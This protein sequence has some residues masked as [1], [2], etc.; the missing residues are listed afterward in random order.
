MA[1]AEWKKAPSSNAVVDITANLP[2]QQFE[3]AIS[4]EFEQ[5]M[6]LRKRSHAINCVICAQTVYFCTV[7]NQ[8][9]EKK[10]D[11]QHLNRN[12]ATRLLMEGIERDPLL[13]GIIGG[14]RLGCHIANALIKFGGVKPAELSISTRRPETLS[15]LQAK[16]V[17]CYYD[18][19]KLVQSVHLIF[20]C[21]LPAQLQLVIDDIKGKLTKKT[22]LYSLVPAAHITR[23][24]QLLNFQF[25]IKPDIVWNYDGEDNWDYSLGFDEVFEK[26]SLVKQTCPLGNAKKSS[27]VQCDSKLAE[28]FIYAVVN[29]CTQFKI[30]RRDTLRMVHDVIF[31]LTDDIPLKLKAEHF[32]RMKEDDTSMPFPMFDLSLIAE[33]DT[34]LTKK[35]SQVDIIHHYVKR[36]CALFEE[37]FYK[38]KWGQGTSQ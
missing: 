20:L 24:R 21:V 14:G 27:M 35:L 18:N 9:R 34:P 25:I 19:A 6:V 12:R 11:L 2:T 1:D 7:L 29:I 3:S 16:G 13:V 4:E 37:H 5:Y 38:A 28:I 10:E 36:Y 31:D 30:C 33:N 23:L 17:K 15:K 8:V 22:V 26:E 32:T